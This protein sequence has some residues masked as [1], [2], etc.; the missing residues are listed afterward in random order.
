[1]SIDVQETDQAKTEGAVT[2]RRT[3]TQAWDYGEYIVVPD[4][5]I[6]GPRLLVIPAQMRDFETA[7]GIV[8]PAHAQKA[9][10]RGLIVLV[11]DG[12]VWDNGVREESRYKP[13]MEIVYAQY[14]GIELELGPNN[15]LIIQV[16]AFWRSTS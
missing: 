13:G 6:V 15:Y 2:L 5:Q 14:A 8:V 10:A 4:I 1:M 11:G 3:Q 9:A 12:V 16:V 7:S